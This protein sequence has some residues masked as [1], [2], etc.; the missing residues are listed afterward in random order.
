MVRPSVVAAG[1]ALFLAGA[2]GANSLPATTVE[3]SL[4]DEMGGVVSFQDPTLFSPASRRIRVSG[5]IFLGD[6]FV[7]NGA[8]LIG[9]L[10]QNQSTAS[11][12]DAGESR[13]AWA[14]FTGDPQRNITAGPSDGHDGS[15]FLAAGAGISTVASMNPLENEFAFEAIIGLGEILLSFGG[16][17]RTISYTDD[18]SSGALFTIEA[19]G[20][21]QGY[22][23]NYD[24]VVQTI[25][26]PGPA[27]MGLAGL[28]LVAAVRRR[29]GPDRSTPNS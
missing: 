6:F 25:P 5:T 22:S 1:G 11:G 21:G 14:F 3:G 19:D 2:A 4:G 10:P 27:A 12:L 18:F 15:G 23:F 17:S 24:L 16:E 26:L 28:G 8:I 13:G 9:L 29:R 20:G 7:E